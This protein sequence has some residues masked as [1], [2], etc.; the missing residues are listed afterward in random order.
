MAHGSRL[1][2]LCQERNE[3][4]ALFGHAPQLSCYEYIFLFLFLF[5]LLIF[6][7]FF[8]LIRKVLSFALALAPARS[9]PALS[10]R[11]N[12]LSCYEYIFLFLFLFLSTINIM[13]SVA[14]MQFVKNLRSPVRDWCVPLLL[15][16]AFRACSCNCG[17][18]P[19]ALATRS[20]PHHVLQWRR[21][22]RMRMPGCSCK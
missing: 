17:P 2:T 18:S 8:A 7:P 16:R 6:Q 9:P 11:L 21:R 22:R 5:R 13:S 12:V 1:S 4:R 19:E 14:A 3:V 10:L 20:P 15:R